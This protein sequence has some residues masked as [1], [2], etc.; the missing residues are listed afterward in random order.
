MTR[1]YENEADPPSHDPWE[2]WLVLIMVLGLCLLCNG[3]C[4]VECSYRSRNL[5]PIPFPTD[6]VP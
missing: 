5:A 6:R 3:G 1:S 2:W 4:G